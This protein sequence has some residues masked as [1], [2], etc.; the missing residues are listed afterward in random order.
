MKADVWDNVWGK[1]LIVSDYSLKYLSYISE[2]EKSL[3]PGSNV[4]E[5]G[6]GTGQ[7]LSI[8]SKRH[9][10]TGFDISKNAL[11]LSRKNCHSP[12]R[13]DLLEMPF[14]DESFDFVYNSGV[15][16]H[17]KE[18]Y[19]I[20]GI[21]EMCR[22]TKKGGHILLIVPNTLCAWYRIY[23]FILSS[24]DKFEFG[25]EEDYSIWRLRNAIRATNYKFEV[26][27]EFGLQLLIP[28]ATNDK[29]VCSE[30]LRRKIGRL[31]KYFPSSLT[32]YI[33]YAVGI[34][35]TKL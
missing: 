31:E 17:F 9:V 26:I 22:I 21:S 23:K 8:F 32:K 10:T 20:K 12:I 3:N 35:V 34:Y 16:E 28:L 30:S 33:A 1:D 5:V 4:I 14:K 19:N 24:F 7:T 25:Y 13:G 11:I 15:I 18:P 6:S 27:S 29:E 2:I